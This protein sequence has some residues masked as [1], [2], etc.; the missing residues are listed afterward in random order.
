MRRGCRI[1]D[2]MV[3]VGTVVLDNDRLDD[4]QLV[5]RLF[6]LESYD[7]GNDQSCRDHLYPVK[8]RAASEISRSLKFTNCLTLSYRSTACYNRLKL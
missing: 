1:G 7:R 3:T 6:E 2:Y 5:V 4:D 8:V